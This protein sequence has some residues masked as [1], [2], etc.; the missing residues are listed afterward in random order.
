MLSAAG[1][2]TAGAKGARDGLAPEAATTQCPDQ[3]GVA[4]SRPPSPGACGEGVHGVC[5]AAHVG[6]EREPGGAAGTGAP[7][8]AGQPELVRVAHDLPPL[9]PRLAAWNAVNIGFAGLGK[10]GLPVALAIE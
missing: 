7:G 3:S 5:A 2:R 8:D 1:R 4:R 6:A 9:G 10:L